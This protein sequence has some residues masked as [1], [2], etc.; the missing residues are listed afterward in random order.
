MTG[1]HIFVRDGSR[2]SHGTRNVPC[3]I[4]LVVVEDWLVVVVVIVVSC[5]PFSLR[6]V[7]GFLSDGAKCEGD[8][9]LRG[10]SC[11]PSPLVRN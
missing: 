1:G 2:L 4:T 9:A 5:V 11:L 6:G 8:G 3:L 7:S 10:H